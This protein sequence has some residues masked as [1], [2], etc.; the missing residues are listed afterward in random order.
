MG[1]LA[2]SWGHEEDTRTQAPKR[3]RHTKGLVSPYSILLSKI[4]NWTFSV[5]AW[6]HCWITKILENNSLLPF[7]S[8]WK[9]GPRVHFCWWVGK[10]VHLISKE[11]L[12]QFLLS[13][14]LIGLKTKLYHSLF[15]LLICLCPAYNLFKI[16][17]S[18]K[19]TFEVT[20]GPRM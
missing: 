1:T 13:V 3:T 20:L 4:A 6:E 5:I 18:P 2:N 8:Y 16:S 9:L 14:L 7:I 10:R 12:A 17:A 19:F 15:L 11:T